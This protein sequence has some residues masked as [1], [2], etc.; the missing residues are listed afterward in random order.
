MKSS[1][2]KKRL[3][4]SFHWFLKCVRSFWNTLYIPTENHGQVLQQRIVLNVKVS[5][6]VRESECSILY[7]VHVQADWTLVDILATHFRAVAKHD[8]GWLHK[9]QTVTEFYLPEEKT[10]VFQKLLFWKMINTN[11]KP[12]GPLPPVKLFKHENQ[13]LYSKTRAAWMVQHK[14]IRYCG[15]RYPKYYGNKRLWLRFLKRLW[16]TPLLHRGWKSNAVYWIHQF[17]LKF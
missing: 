6:Y 5:V 15:Q 10:K 1:A 7:K 12:N 4:F 2:D 9:S 14:H 13:S 11:M 16:L 3:W 8:L 17:Y